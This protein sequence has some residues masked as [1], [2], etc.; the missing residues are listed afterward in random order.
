MPEYKIVW[1]P[2]AAVG[3]LSTT[4]QPVEL[5][6][7]SA[8]INQWAAAGWRVHQVTPAT[9]PTVLWGLYVTFVHD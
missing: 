1:F 4:E 6:Q 2:G 7:I 5:T 8:H 3:V 9:A